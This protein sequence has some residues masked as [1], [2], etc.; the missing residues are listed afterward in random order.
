M[1]QLEVTCLADLT[2][3]HNSLGVRTLRCQLGAPVLIVAALTH[4]L[5]V[6]LVGQVLAVRDL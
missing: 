1:V 4:A 6:V 5:G 2:R 3:I